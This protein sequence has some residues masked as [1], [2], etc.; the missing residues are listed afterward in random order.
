MWHRGDGLK[1]RITDRKWRLVQSS[2]DDETNH[3]LVVK[4]L[5]P[6]QRSEI[7][8][9]AGG[10]EGQQKVLQYQFATKGW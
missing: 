8:L 2:L 10:P 6:G 7:M 9:V 3:T 4:E 5:V 1:P